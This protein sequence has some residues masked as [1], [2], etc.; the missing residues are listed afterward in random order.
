[1]CQGSRNSAVMEALSHLCES[2]LHDVLVCA[3]VLWTVGV[4]PMGGL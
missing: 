1:M 4:G 2:L 3:Y